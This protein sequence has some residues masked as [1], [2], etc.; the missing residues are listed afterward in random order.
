[1]EPWL[2]GSLLNLPGCLRTD[3]RRECL[4]LRDRKQ[5]NSEE[6][7]KV[8]LRNFIISSFH[9][10]AYFLWRYLPDGV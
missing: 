4:G 3:Y 5:Q 1:M 2:N 10:I 6:N 9:H 8:I 7:L